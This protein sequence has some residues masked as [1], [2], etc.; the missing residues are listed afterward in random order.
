[1]PFVSCANGAPHTSLGQ[2]PRGSGPLGS[3][4]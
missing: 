3:A 2:R 1:V 4:L